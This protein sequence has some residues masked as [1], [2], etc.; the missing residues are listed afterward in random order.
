MDLIAHVRKLG[1]EIVK[2]DP[3]VRRTRRHSEIAQGGLP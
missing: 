2:P 1:L 3:F